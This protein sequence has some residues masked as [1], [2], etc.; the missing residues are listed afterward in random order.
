MQQITKILK[1]YATPLNELVVKQA[2]ISEKELE[3]MTAWQRS[4]YREIMK[5][6]TKN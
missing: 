2:T 4:S 1:T 3:K 6:A 5:F